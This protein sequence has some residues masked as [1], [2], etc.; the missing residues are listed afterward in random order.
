MS[1]EFHAAV[2]AMHENNARRFA[3]ND[4]ANKRHVTCRIDDCIYVYLHEDGVH[5]QTQCVA[6]P[7]A[8]WD[9]WPSDTTVRRRI[10]RCAEI[11]SA[12]ITSLDD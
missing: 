11:G 8:W 12:R 7:D 6:I 9:N 10:H 2:A 4:D 5:M 1:R 3:A